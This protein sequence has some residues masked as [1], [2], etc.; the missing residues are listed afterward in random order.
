MYEHNSSEVKSN[1]G[2]PKQKGW[3]NVPSS[4][5]INKRAA[6]GLL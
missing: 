1:E 2:I 4:A 6:L 3:E 5:R